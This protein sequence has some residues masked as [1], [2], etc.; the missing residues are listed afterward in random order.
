MRQRQLNAD[1]EALAL[2]QRVAARFPT[3]PAVDAVQFVTTQQAR[4]GSYSAAT[5]TIRLNAALRHMPGWVLEAVVAHELAH[6]FFQDHGPGFWKLL[7]SVEP[8]VD[9][10]DAFLAG[11]TWLGHYWESLPP[12]ERGLLARVQGYLDDANDQAQRD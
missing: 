6:V 7:R 2:V 1:D 5:R 11:V 4:W 3:R 12:V 8:A 9:R 10:A